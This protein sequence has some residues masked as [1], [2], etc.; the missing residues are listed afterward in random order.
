MLAKNFLKG[1]PVSLHVL[2]YG[3]FRVHAND[4]VIG[5]CG[6]LIQTDAGESVLVDTGLPKKYAEDKAAA[7]KADRLYEFGEVLE[8]EMANM[9]MHQLQLAG[10]GPDQINLH[11]LTHTHIDHV[12][13]LHDF[14]KVPI[15]VS[16]EERRLPKPLYWG[17]I[18]PLEW[19]D[20]EYLVIE[21]DIEIGPKF[22]VLT[23]PGHAPG[24]LSLMLELPKTGPILLTS[25]AISR[26]AEIDEKFIGSWDEPM[27]ISSAERLMQLANETGAFVIYGHSPEQWPTLK[28]SPE[29]YI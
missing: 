10:V 27:A 6:F 20:E 22:R 14:P 1:R 12:G 17:K 26:P 18:Q 21:G 3:L 2:D 7:T 16:G 29:A 4:R 8:C 24:Q 25:D 13:G 11:I 28:K 19:P 23:V 9:P 15:L 5:I